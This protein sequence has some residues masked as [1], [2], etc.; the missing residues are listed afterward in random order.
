MIVLDEAKV[1]E[2]VQREVLT[3]YPETRLL[4]LF[5][6]RARDRA[7]P[8]SDYDFLVVTPTEDRYAWRGT[9]LRLA[10][11]PIDA[12]FDFIV[13]TPEEYEASCALPWSVAASAVREGR[14]LHAV[15]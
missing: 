6:S 12:A 4:V 2:R 15:A 5:G 1:I 13:L 11:R 10:L 9:K 14:V 7:E 3:L 8:D